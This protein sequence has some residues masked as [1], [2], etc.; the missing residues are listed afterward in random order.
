LV[1]VKSPDSKQV[2][3][4]MVPESSPV[5]QVELA[6][7][8]QTP[9]N[10]T[11]EEQTVLEQMLIDDPLPPTGS[12]DLSNHAASQHVLGQTVVD[13][14]SL[15]DTKDISSSVMRETP[16]AATTSENGSIS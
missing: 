14:V 7:Q 9:Q 6:Q 16:V 2:S 11:S 12:G 4:D 15:Q 3:P 13:V 1:E 5:S 10:I 8:L